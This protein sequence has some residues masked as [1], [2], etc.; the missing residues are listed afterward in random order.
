MLAEACPANDR[1]DHAVTP[2]LGE[3]GILWPTGDARADGAPHLT[4][5]WL[6]T[7]GT[8]I[9]VNT[10]ATPQQ[11][12][13]VR[14]DPRVAVDVHSPAQAYRIANVRGRVVELT[15]AGADEHVDGLAKKY[16]GTDQYPFRRPGQQRVILNIRPERIHSI[17]LDNDGR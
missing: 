12:R 5:V 1:R 9:L 17:G 2:T 3:G 16:L 6:D 15:T 8:H 4:K 13:N 10:V 11:T 14:R 7:D